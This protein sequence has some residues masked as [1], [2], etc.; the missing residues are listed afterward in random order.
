MFRKI[1][2]LV[3][4][5]LVMGCASF[6]GLGGQY[7]TTETLTLSK[8]PANFY[9][10]V[11]LVGQEL[12]YQHTGGNKSANSVNL[13]DQPNFGET[14]IGRNYSVQATIT[15]KPDGRTVEILF[16][17]V[18]SRSTAAAKKSQERIDQ[19]KAAL[20]QKFRG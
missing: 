16:V 3:L 14:M 10:D 12:G 11:I 15:L 4:A 20:S 17:A 2:A 6:S 9:D 5:T 13:S 1:F 19:L 18:G 8:R 7:T